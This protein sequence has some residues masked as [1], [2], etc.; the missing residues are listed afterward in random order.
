[1][2]KLLVISLN[3]RTPAMTLR[4]VQHALREMQGLEAELVIVDNDSGDGSFE[5]MHAVARRLTSTF[6]IFTTVV[7]EPFRRLRRCCKISIYVHTANR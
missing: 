4:S 2:P 5:A 1:M 3:Y 7:T 6:G